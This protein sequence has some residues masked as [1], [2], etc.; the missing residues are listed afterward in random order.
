MVKVK[1]VM[2]KY[3]ITV[4]PSL[5]IDFIAKIMTNN[6]VGSVVILDKQKPV[7]IVTS[8]D[9]V[10]VIS[11]GLS[12]KKTTA[13]D[14]VKRGFITASPDD[15]LMHVARM[16]VQKGIKRIPIITAGK[17]EGIL[18]DKEILV[19]TPEMIDVL[20]EKLKARVEKVAK[21]DDV[22]SGICESCDEYDDNLHSVGGRWYCEECSE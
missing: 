20:S 3:V 18:T 7:G 2:R 21:P 1:E 13:K 15:D 11:K 10:S 16:M 6:R 5:S 19:T 17:L 14:F 22:I 4:D 8:E 9:I 12:P